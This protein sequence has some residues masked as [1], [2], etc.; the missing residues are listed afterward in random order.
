MTASPI[1]WYNGIIKHWVVT[2]TKEDMS[3]TTNEREELQRRCF[4][5]TKAILDSGVENAVKLVM[6]PNAHKGTK[7]MTNDELVENYE[8]LRFNRQSIMA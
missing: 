3:M 2:I 8:I 4:M 6:T 1:I 5:T 7:G